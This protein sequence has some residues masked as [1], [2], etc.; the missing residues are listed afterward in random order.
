MKPLALV[1]NDDGI[2]SAFLH[3][4][5]RALQAE[6]RVAVAAP[7]FEQ[8][9]IGRAMTRKGE[10]DVIP[11]PSHF[12]DVESAWAIGGT[13][14]DCVNIAL[15]NLLP[16]R[17][18]IVCSGINIGFNTTETLILSSG[19]VAGAI[20]G[21]LWGLP[22][23]AFSK[24]VPHEI[25]AQVA[26]QRGRTE[27]AFASSLQCAAARACNLARETL[28]KPET[29]GRVININ[30]PTETGLDTAVED[31][32]PARIELGSLFEEHRPGKYR[33]RFKGGTVCESSEASDRSVLEA[34][35]I[36]RSVLDFSRIGRPS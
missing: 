14:S 13:P 32:V 21:A 31:T 7:A 10:I 1:T 17:P 11:S 2:D 35:R 16:E 8:S 12:E 22:S 30:F 23:L 6:F 28:E 4:L 29:P 33:F 26:E 25:F 19:T 15:G 9:W 34:G 18:A 27:G 36:S 24:C 5:V 3:E 20:E